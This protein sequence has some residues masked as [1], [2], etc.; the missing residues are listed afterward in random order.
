MVEIWE[1]PAHHNC[2]GRS[3]ATAAAA[4]DR[5]GDVDERERLVCGECAHWRSDGKCTLR[6]RGCVDR[7]LCPLGRFG[8]GDFSACVTLAV[9]TFLRHWCLERLLQSIRKYYPS[10]RRIVQDTQGN[11][12]W[13]RNQIVRRCKTPFVLFFDDDFLLRP[14]SNLQA[15]LSVMRQ[16]DDLIAVCG[17]LYEDGKPVDYASDLRIVRR[18]LELVQ[19]P[20]HG[21]RT[22]PENTP[23][24]FCDMGFNFFL[25]RRE[26][27]LEHPWDEDLPLMEHAA[28]FWA[29]REQQR[30]RVAFTPTAVADHAQDLTDEEYNQYRLQASNYQSVISLKYGWD[31]IRRYEAPPSAPSSVTLPTY[32]P[33]IVVL[34][35]GHSGTTVFTRQIAA[36]GWNLCDADDTFAESVSVR[37]VNEQFVAGGEFSWKEARAVYKQ[38]RS[39]WVI[40]DPRFVLAIEKWRSVW[41]HNPPLLVYLSRDV[42]QLENSY[43]RRGECF[44]DGRP[45]AFGRPLAELVDKAR[46]Y[47]RRWP[48]WKITF[49]FGDFNDAVG[50]FDPTAAVSS[51]IPRV[52]HRFWT[53]GEMPQRF[54]EWIAD[55]RKLHPHWRHVLWEEDHAAGLL[56]DH[57]P[58]IFAC[59]R[60]A[61][62][63]AQKSDCLRH[64]VLHRQ[65]GVFLDVDFRPLRRIDELLAGCEAFAVQHNQTGVCAATPL[66]AVAGHPLTQRIVEAFPGRWNPADQLATGPRLVDA[67]VRGHNDCRILEARLF[68]P[69]TFLE[70]AELNDT[71]RYAGAYAVH[72]FAGSWVPHV[73]QLFCEAEAEH[74]Q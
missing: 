6:R 61:R 57:Y 36:L 49:D 34:G 47:Y 7:N 66:G 28:W 55:W 60:Q 42:E 70:R 13:G 41:Q 44:P 53:G 24:R 18:Q 73:K 30:W 29:N 40:K 21:W 62:N 48:W 52:Q 22:T 45:G 68:F 3:R 11:L 51:P 58:Q 54:R 56:R 72:H 5:R 14:D 63:A 26:A 1:L 39:P 23:Y 37:A 9:T 64:A 20:A 71:E 69:R 50:L 10:N 17:R 15:L 67:C 27:L 38:L 59:W 12:S 32:K 8:I 43:R 16:H 2:P 46:L 65:G 35:V 19:P 25:G 33:N 4:A 31:S 74:R